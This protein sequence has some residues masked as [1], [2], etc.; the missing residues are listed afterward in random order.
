MKCSTDFEKDF[1]SNILLS[2][3]NT[4]VPG[5]GER[6][7]KEI[8]TLAPPTTTKI[9]VVT[10][11]NRDYSVWTGGSMIASMSTFKISSSPRQSTRSAG[12]VLCIGEFFR[13]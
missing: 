11:S 3:G 9:K 6:M 13:W 1:Y 4:M 12:P 2:G 10:P 8:K 5:I 7:T